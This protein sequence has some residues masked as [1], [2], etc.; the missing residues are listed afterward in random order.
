[1][2][3]VTTRI[4]EKLLGDKGLCSEGT[5]LNLI[6]ITAEKFLRQGEHGLGT[7]GAS[8]EE[9]ISVGK[10][11]EPNLTPTLK[12]WRLYIGKEV[13][14]EGSGIGMI[15]VSLDE[16]IRSYAIR[17]NFKASEHSRDYEA[18]LAGLV[19]SIGQGIKDIHVF[20][21]SPTL[22]AQ[23]EGSYAPAMRQ[24]RKYKEEIIDEVSIGIKTRPS[25]EETSS[26]KTG[27]AVSNVPGAKPKKCS[28]EADL[29]KDTS[30]LEP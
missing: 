12:A 14:E 29:S 11:H 3:R 17:L 30:G 28:G 24:E 21:D 20:I 23:I 16:M 2:S 9:T 4:P 10:E 7:L 13:V 19:A 5:K 1:M 15:L 26:N 27:K 22:A 25:V 18:L 8:K 6:F